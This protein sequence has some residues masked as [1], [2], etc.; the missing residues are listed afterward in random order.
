MKKNS[1]EEINEENYLDDDDSSDDDHVSADVNR[2]PTGVREELKLWG[3]YTTWHG[4][5][6]I[7]R[8]SNWPI[9]L[10]WLSLF[11]ATSAICCYML[12]TTFIQY[13]SYEVITKI[14]QTP[15]KSLLFPAVTV[16]NAE[17]FATRHANEYVRRHFRE[18]FGVEAESYGTLV[19]YFER[20]KL[21]AR[22]A[23]DEIDELRQATYLRG[24][25]NETLA[26]LMGYTLKQMFFS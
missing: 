9:R 8:A 16:C 4:V 1:Q 18:N 13:F 25:H 24:Q 3:K 14:R 10:F 21:M 20:N 17:F 7:F 2:E 19:E 26:N 6:I 22:T 23:R 5:P 15:K 11:L 12:A